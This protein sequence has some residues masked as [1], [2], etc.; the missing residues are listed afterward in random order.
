MPLFLCRWPNGECSVVLA[1]TRED[2]IVELDQVGNAEG[3][4]I[5]RMRTFQL[6]F[7][8]TDQ[9]DLSLEQFGGGKAVN[10]IETPRVK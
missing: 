3:C 10:D 9:G 5:T 2:A 4:P 6:Q 7:A 1:P 8:L